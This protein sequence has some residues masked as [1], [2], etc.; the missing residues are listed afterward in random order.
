M[1]MDEFLAK[2]ALEMRL[3][4]T[5]AEKSLWAALRFDPIWMCQVPLLGSYIADFLYPP[6]GLVVEADGG[7]HDDELQQFRDVQRDR[8]MMTDGLQVLRLTN[9]DIYHRLPWVLACIHR[10]M[11][12]IRIMRGEPTAERMKLRKRSRR[13]T[14]STWGKKPLG[15]R[16]MVAEEFPDP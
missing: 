12:V 6:L 15:L 7:Y 3:A 9:R 8:V 4:P 5:K 1:S 13:A 2:R 16:E 11:N 10:R 14:A